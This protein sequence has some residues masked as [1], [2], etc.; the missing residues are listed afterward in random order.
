MRRLWINA[1]DFGLTRGVSEGILRAMQHGVVHTTTAMMCA[2]GARERIAALNGPIAGRIGLHLQ[3]TDGAALGGGASFPRQSKSL[4][5][6][7]T[8]SVLREWRLQLAGMRAL[9]LEPTHLDTHH[10]VHWRPGALEAYIALACEEQLPARGGPDWLVRR[11]RSEG[12]PSAGV[13]RTFGD[14]AGVSLE[15]FVAEAKLAAEECGEDDFV[16][17]SCHPGYAD[18]ELRLRSVYVSQREAELELLC[19]PELPERLRSAG[20]ELAP[21]QPAQR[22]LARL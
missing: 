18:D 6:L 2:P 3:L 13:T 10:D 5:V 15:G 9:G 21:L 19:H 12:I 22:P 4:G 20:L 1:D 7:E 17:I 16:E 8:E 11:L 14:H